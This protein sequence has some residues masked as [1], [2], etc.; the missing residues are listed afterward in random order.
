[1]KNADDV[2]DAAGK[3]AK[4]G[5]TVGKAV[6]KGILKKIPVVSFFAGLAFGID[7]MLDGD[8]KGGGLEMVSGLAGNIPVVGTA[9][10]AGID[11]YLLNEDLKKD[12][13][14]F[15]MTAPVS[16]AKEAAAVA[17]GTGE[18]SV[19]QY[20]LSQRERLVKEAALLKAQKQEDKWLKR[21]KEDRAAKYTERIKQLEAELG[22][23]K[24]N[25]QMPAVAE[26]LEG[27][28]S[29]A[30]T[31]LINGVVTSNTEQTQILVDIKE[32]I[33]VLNGN[34]QLIP[35]AVTTSGQKT[36]TAVKEASPYAN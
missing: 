27:T 10:G 23:A 9:A 24:S 28:Y 4:T 19:Q 33:S 6:T 14:G 22:R 7:R 35:Q 30:D 2:A 29:S 12:G 16:A 13:G 15:N 25:I 32:A 26:G 31:E 1:M 8:F 21:G 36:A 11:A 34:V 5:K 20:Q 3:A 18:G 17:H